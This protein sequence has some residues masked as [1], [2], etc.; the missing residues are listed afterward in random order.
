MKIRLFLAAVAAAF[1]SVSAGARDRI[2]VDLN[3]IE[4]EMTMNPSLYRGLLDRFVKA[5]T[6]L[7]TEEMA[8]VY[9]GQGF[10]F[11]YDPDVTFPLISEAYDRK[12]YATVTELADAVLDEYPLSLDLLV[13]GLVSATRDQT[14]GHADVA[15]KLQ[16]RFDMIVDVIMS[17]GNGISASSPFYIASDSDIDHLLRDVFAVSAVVGSSR[18]GTGDVVAYKVTFPGSDREHI[19]YFNSALQHRYDNAHKK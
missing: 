4:V 10:T 14:P 5:D 16:Q 3:R 17:S 2:N 18:V 19:L 6:T 8:T 7:T 11:D 12:D 1:I 13:M 9:Y 15:P